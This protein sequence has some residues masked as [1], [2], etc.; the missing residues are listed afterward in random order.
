M[1]IILIQQPYIENKKA[2]S[3]NSVIIKGETAESCRHT[4]LS[5]L[6]YW[7]NI[8]PYHNIYCCQQWQILI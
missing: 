8:K 2:N 4:L 1:V 7:A 3:D 5:V 6:S